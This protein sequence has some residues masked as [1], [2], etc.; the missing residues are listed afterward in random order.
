MELDY[1]YNPLRE[2]L[3]REPLKVR[4]GLFSPPEKPG[5]GVEL[6][7]EA[8]ERFAFSGSED[9]VVRRETLRMV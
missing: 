7:P 2:E 9:L 3:L 6:D 8:V 1:T 4:G 5:L